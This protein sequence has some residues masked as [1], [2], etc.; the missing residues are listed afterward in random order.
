MKYAVLLIASALLTIACPSERAPLVASDI[1]IARPL[2]G[3]QMTAGYMT[4]TNNTSQQITLT[5]VASPQFAS[6]Q[7]HETV[8]EDGIAK[9]HRLDAVAIPP[10]DSLVFEPG[11]KHL[12]LMQANGATENVT[13]EF[14]ADKAVLLSVN[15]AFTD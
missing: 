1:A 9:M 8:I 10:G 2:P 14:T 15:V 11:A 3:M 13:L 7:M 6:V 4:L 5:K 12:M